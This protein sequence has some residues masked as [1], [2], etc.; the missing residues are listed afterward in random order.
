LVNFLLVIPELTKYSK[1]NIDIGNTPLDVYDLC[2]CIRETFCLSYSI[3]KN[4]NL[5]LY[6]QNILTLI[7]F[8]GE[9]LRYLGPDERSQALL[10][11][12]AL[13]KINHLPTTNSW[14]KSTPGIF[15]RKF[16]NES[17]M[18]IYFKSLLANKFIIIYKDNE[19]YNFITT[20]ESFSFESIKNY[21]FILP[22]YN[23]LEGY[24]DFLKNLTVPTKIKYFCLPSIKSIENKILLINFQIDRIRSVVK[25]SKNDFRER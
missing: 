21:F 16:N 18:I 7:K 8:E 4:N 23:E 14:L 9:R 1:K 5:Y 17:S 15:F 22:I 11:K 12:K 25:Q 2:S 20:S 10:L 24:S 13:D 3:R 6:F 19:K